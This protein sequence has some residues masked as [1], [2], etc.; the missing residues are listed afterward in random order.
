MSFSLGWVTAGVNSP[1][2]ICGADGSVVLLPG[3]RFGVG[4]EQAR[5]GTGTGQTNLVVEL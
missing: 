4:Q 1:S 5:T 2:G 3:R